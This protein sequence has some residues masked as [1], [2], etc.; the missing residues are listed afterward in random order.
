MSTAST[1]SDESQPAALQDNTDT[2]ARKVIEPAQPAHVNDVDHPLTPRRRRSKRALAV[3]QSSRTT[4]S[5]ARHQ[6]PEEMEAPQPSSPTNQ[7][8]PID[9]DEMDESAF[10]PLPT[11][12]I[13][14]SSHTPEI[15]SNDHGHDTDPHQTEDE[16]SAPATS[17]E[18]SGESISAV[19]PKASASPHASRKR[20][21]VE[22]KE[23][24]EIKDPKPA[25]IYKRLKLKHD[26]K[27]TPEEI[28]A[29]RAKEV[30]P[31]TQT[32][33]I[34]TAEE[35]AAMTDLDADVVGI[36]VASGPAKR[37]RGSRGGFRGRTRGRGR[38]R[39][40]RGGNTAPARA[41][42]ARARGQK[43]GR[44][45]RAAPAARRGGKKVEDEIWEVETKR[46]S[47]SPVPETKKIK[48]RQD[49]LAFLF[50]KVGAAQQL[51]LGAMADQN[52]ANLAK[53]KHAHEDCPE[54]AAVKAELDEEL[55]KHLVVL[56]HTYNLKTEAEN[57]VYEGEVASLNMRTE[58]MI[59]SVQDEMFH[60][61]RGK[62][63]E[64]MM[65]QR[66]A[67]DD[68]HTETDGSTAGSEEPQFL[69]AKGK[70][71]AREV[72]R[73]F[74]ADAVREPLGA[75][76]YE[77]AFKTWDDFVT[78][79]QMENDVKPQ[80]RAL[81]SGAEPDVQ[82]VV[83]RSMQMLL[84][85]SQV[86]DNDQTG[87]QPLPTQPAIHSLDGA[88]DEPVPHA[89]SSLAEIALAEAM[90]AQPL[91]HMRSRALLPPQPS[92]AVP[93]PGAGGMIGHGP[94]DPRSFILPRPTPTTQPRR[95]LPARGQL[96]LPDPFAMT[97]PPQLP[98]PPGSNFT[99]LPVPNYLAPGHQGPPGP[100]Y[101]PHGRR[102]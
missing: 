61:V 82:D 44:A 93:P 22:L 47:P 35:E 3:P 48:E 59:K 19:Q 66:A 37:G 55:R 102:F 77:L 67:E 50:K 52:M 74:D 16:H 92:Q 41:A 31:Q 14:K 98:P 96:G 23:E 87:A 40:G 97:G 60:A 26:A 45:T 49:K 39:G 32:P 11:T 69:F 57:R 79:V 8:S 51:A 86:A 43:R 85:A 15:T 29:E 53:D 80:L 78:K 34:T 88:Y 24:P 81:D 21:T 10:E 1:S 91:P 28:A 2:A 83:D 20:K 73:G 64:L 25:P 30:Q 12:H 76:A 13:T 99:R 56:S 38:G 27:P 7:M 4:R 6:S 62:V 70:P 33:D 58:A 9:H 18:A 84:E 95:I 63:I 89:L 100:M 94:T 68:E 101:Y 54:W 46:R 17:P 75:D 71:G 65:G 5:A 90:H 72:V 36:E 42:A